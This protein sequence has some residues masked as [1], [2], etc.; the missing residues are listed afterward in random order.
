MAWVGTAVAAVSAIYGIS[1]AERGKMQAKKLLKK[2]E[3]EQER[4]DKIKGMQDMAARNKALQEQ[5]QLRKKNSGVQSTLL[6]GG[7]KTLG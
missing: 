3:R 6:T 5:E 7:S 4:Q 2:D 1:E